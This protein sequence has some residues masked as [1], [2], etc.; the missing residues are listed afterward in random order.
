MFDCSDVQQSPQSSHHNLKNKTL[1]YKGCGYNSVCRMLI[2]YDD[3]LG[4][5]SRPMSQAIP[6]CLFLF[7]LKS[8]D[9]K[10]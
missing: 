8:I 7:S 4:L 2:F 5:I 1:S 6:Q 10:F 3:A 9:L